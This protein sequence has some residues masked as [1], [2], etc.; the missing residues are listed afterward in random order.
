MVVLSPSMEITEKNIRLSFIKRRQIVISREKEM[1]TFV[2]KVQIYIK[3][4]ER[5]LGGSFQEVGLENRLS[6]FTD[7]ERN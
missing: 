1:V 7:F 2:W 4:G 6:T 5:K 3:G